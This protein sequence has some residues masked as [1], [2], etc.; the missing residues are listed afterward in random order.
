MKKYAW[1]MM[2]ALVTGLG[3]GFSEQIK[4]L[5]HELTTPK[6]GIAETVPNVSKVKGSIPVNYATAIPT[7]NG[8]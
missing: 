8:R 2:L 5:I 3:I 1:Q 7:C 6:Q 4:S